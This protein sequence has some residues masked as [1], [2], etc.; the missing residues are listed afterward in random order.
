MRS[1]GPGLGCRAACALRCARGSRRAMAAAPWWPPPRR[2]LAAAA[3]GRCRARI[4]A[5]PG[6]RAVSAAAPE[7]RAADAF[8]RARG[9]RRAVSA[10]PLGRCL[11]W[12]CA[13]PWCSRRA[14]GSA[15]A[16]LAASTGPTFAP[17]LLPR[18]C[19]AAAPL[20]PSTGPRFAPLMRSTGP[21]F[22][23]PRP[24]G[25]WR[26]RCCCRCAGGFY[27][28]EARAAS[29]AVPWRPPPL[30]RFGCPAMEPAPRPRFAPCP[31]ALV[32]STG[33]RFAPLL[34]SAAPELRLPRPG[35]AAAPVALS[36]APEARLPRPCGTAAPWCR[37]RAAGGS[38]VPEVRAV[39]CGGAFH[40][41]QG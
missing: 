41:A 13:A 9:A 22:Q 28:P 5:A 32:A 15:A 26:P 4:R 30:P 8:H 35:A 29:A 3:L 25:P 34:P 31:G 17:C 10:A 19:A 1:T 39:R 38:S 27:A 11:A 37:C 2:A 40:R 16:A 14:R 33:P 20:A 36:T 6:V 21:E 12:G 7:V 24:G 18:P 23:L